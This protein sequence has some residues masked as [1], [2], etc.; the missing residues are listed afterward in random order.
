VNLP[1]DGSEPSAAES[2][3]PI[4][5]ASAAGAAAS[6]APVG[7]L[8]RTLKLFGPGLVTGA[9]DDDPSGIAT[10]SSDTYIG[11]AFSNLIAYFIMLTER[12][13]R[14]ESSNHQSIR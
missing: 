8:Q 13:V 11:M 10:Y 1:P 14:N 2:G 7:W 9:A 12:S 3:P 4:Q 6:A 5:L